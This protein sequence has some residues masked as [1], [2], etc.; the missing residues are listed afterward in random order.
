MKIY[1][2]IIYI[3][4]LWYSSSINSEDWVTL[5]LIPFSKLSILASALHT[6]EDK[7]KTSAAE[8]DSDFKQALEDIANN[9]DTFEVDLENVA[10][11]PAEASAMASR[12]AK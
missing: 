12:Q 7:D 6:G 5:T 1:M 9:D 11:D 3:H 4:N 2:P 8:S 10:K